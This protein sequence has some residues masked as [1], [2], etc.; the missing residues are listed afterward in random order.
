MKRDFLTVLDLSAQEIIQIVKRAAE[1]KSGTD[2]MK[3][4]L[5]GKS[6]GLIF[7]KSSTRT[8]VSFEV[9]VYQLGGQ[10][11]TLNTEDIQLG[12]GETV[13][14][15]ASTLSRYLSAIAVR[16]FEHERIEEFAKNAAVPVINTLTDLHHPCQALADLLTVYEKYNKLEGIKMAYIG[17]GNNVANSL[18]EAAALTGMEL[19]LACPAGY[20]PDPDILERA[21]SKATAPITVTASSDEAAANADAL[22]TDVWVSMGQEEEK[23]KRVK[24]F[25]GYQINSAL[26]GQAKPGALVMHCLPAYRGMEI[27][28]EVL[29]GPQSV[30]FDQAENRLH[31]QKALLEFLLA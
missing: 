17:D 4:P 3:C 16:T 28:A 18:I 23:N 2:A 7:E 27:S 10:P 9:G 29:E 22:Y 15:T 21:K 13:A 14:D 8:R 19:A 31:A 11:I 5:K 24:D 1:L 12:R 30:A 20:E 6:V 25:A 26:L